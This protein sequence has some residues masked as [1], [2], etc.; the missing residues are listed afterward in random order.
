MKD[1]RMAYGILILSLA[2]AIPGWA[3]QDKDGREFH[4]TGKLAVD[5]TVAVKTINGEVQAEPASG[6]EVEVSA[7]AFGRH[8]DEVKFEVRQDADGVTI[9]ETYP[10]HDSCTGQSSGHNNNDH[11]RV[12][13]KI[14]VPAGNRFSARSVNGN[15]QAT[16]L[17]RQVKVSTVNGTVKVST[18]SWAEAESVNGSVEAMM[19]STEWSGTL[20]LSSVNGAIRVGLPANA[21]TDVDVRTVN[22]SF[23]SDFPVQANNFMSRHIQGRVGSGGRELKLDSVNGSVH[24]VKTG[25]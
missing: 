11:T 15:I 7:Q 23:Q 16:N 17:E 22:G 6:G 1:R 25:S 2:L 14:R 8:A 24:L 10:N 3:A 5:Q 12:V 21:N 9:C 13:Y 19:E 4:W 20:H 18:R